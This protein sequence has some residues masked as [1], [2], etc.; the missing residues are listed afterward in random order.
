MRMTYRAELLWVFLN[1]LSIQH[2]SVVLA[3]IEVFVLLLS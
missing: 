3:D 1:S 2:L